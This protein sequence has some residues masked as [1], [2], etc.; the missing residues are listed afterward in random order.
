MIPCIT[1]PDVACCCPLLPPGAEVVSEELGHK[2]DKVEANMLGSAKKVTV[3]KDDTILLHGAGDKQEIQNRSDQIRE[4][5]ET[6][7]SDYDRDKLQERLAKLSGGIAVIKIG[8][9]SE[10]EVSEKKDRVEDALNATKA[11]VEE[12]IVA[13]GG[14]ALLHASKEL[15]PLKEKLDNFDQQIG[16]Q[17]LQNA[18]RVSALSST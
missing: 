18:L 4:A 1:C 15:K 14:A 3:T 9:A 11:A 16:I 6:T 10:V 8:G 12:G 7:T 13:G 2:L 5:I 17:I